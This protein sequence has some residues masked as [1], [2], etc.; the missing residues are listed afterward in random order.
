MK[1]FELPETLDGLSVADLQALIDAGLDAFN[2][3]GISESSADDVLAEGERIAPL[4]TRAR[5][6]QRVAEA[7]AVT[8]RDRAAQLNQS[9]QADQTPAEPEAPPTPDEP[10]PP[11]QEPAHQAQAEAPEPVT[12]TETV[13]PDA[14]LT[15]ASGARTSPARRAAA[16]TTVQVEAPRRSAA[17]A[18][19]TAAAD[20]PGI[21]TG[22][23]LEGLDQVAAAV[24]ARMKGLPNANLGNVRHRYGAA[25]IRLG[26]YDDLDQATTQDDYGLIWRA[27]MEERLP[28][29][30]LVA[31]GG[32][33]APS[34][35]LYDLCQ[36]EAVD[37]LL[38]MP[39]VNITRGGIRWTEGPQFSDIYNDCGFFQTEA[40][41]LA[42]QLKTCCT[43]DCP[44]FDEIRLDLIGLCIKAPLLLQSAYPELTRRF[45]EGA[46]VAHQHKVNKYVIAA[47]NASAG[48]GV[49]IADGGSVMASLQQLEMLAIAMRYQYRMSQTASIELIAPFWLKAIIRADM[50]LKA[51]GDDNGASDAEVDA[52]FSSRNFAVQWVYDY[53]DLVVNSCTPTVPATVEMLM[54]PA[55]TWVRGRADVINIDAVYDSTG[56]ESNVYTALFTEEGILAVQRCTHTCKVT[57]TPCISGNRGALDITNC[58][59]A[60]TANAVAAVRALA[61]TPGEWEPTGAT[62][63]ATSAAAGAVVASPGSRWTTGQYV[64]GS[65]AGAAGEMYWNGSAWTAGK[66]P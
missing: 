14:V 48:G 41:A 46:L 56:L 22:A 2:S 20:V 61:G 23:P 4:I 10:Q 21:P 62:P 54:Y 40:Q 19:L 13:Q 66:A 8:R 44:P 26:G 32:W 15:P 60:Y 37:G 5:E 25:T 6:A 1:P 59:A 35:T 31:A 47:I 63:P 3:L 49:T 28:N 18:T 30:S 53:Q 36:F 55:G 42:G 7:L 39:E 64:Q 24:I 65:T 12:V 33:C 58:L 34:E 38:S 16:N 27:G 45:M 11:P 17:V 57:L 43:V 51:F 29:A 9:V 50:G 52:W